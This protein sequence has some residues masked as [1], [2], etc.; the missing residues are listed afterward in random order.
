MFIYSQST[1]IIRRGDVLVGK[2][3]SGQGEGRN[4]PAMESIRSV[5]PIPRGQ[6]HIGPAYDAPGLGP[7]IMPLTPVGHDAL[8]RS[9]FFIHGDSKKG[10]A[11]HGCIVLPRR[12]RKFVGA[13]KDR[14]LLVM[15]GEETHATHR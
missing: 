5:G 14:G 2:G 9:G 13:S 12:A 11:S 8:G 3:Y 7:C 1:G 15:E 6:Y 4:N 10:N